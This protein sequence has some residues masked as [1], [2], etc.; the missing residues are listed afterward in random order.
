MPSG[1]GPTEAG[2]SPGPALIGRRTLDAWPT[3]TH[4]FQQGHR[5]PLG[6]ASEIGQSSLASKSQVGASD[7]C[8]CELV[9]VPSRPSSRPPPTGPMP[10]RHQRFTGAVTVRN[11][12]CQIGH[13]LLRRAEISSPAG[14]RKRYHIAGFVTCPGD[15]GHGGAPPAWV[16]IEQASNESFDP[17]E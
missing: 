15:S 8:G 1:A 4:R 17:V 16:E 7:T 5:L 14:R 3:R 6:D 2:G 13:E 10:W 12:F 9:T 11:L